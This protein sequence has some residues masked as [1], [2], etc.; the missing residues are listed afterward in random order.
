MQRCIALH[1]AT[2]LPVD[3]FTKRYLT[4]S[5]VI[6]SCSSLHLRTSPNHPCY[7]TPYRILSHHSL[8]STLSC[9]ALHFPVPIVIGVTSRDEYE[10]I[11]RDIRYEFYGQVLKFTGCAGV[12]FGHHSGDVEEN[13]IS[14]V[15]RSD[16]VPCVSVSCVL[17]WS[18][19]LVWCDPWAVALTA[20]A[21]WLTC[22]TALDST[23]HCHP[24][25]LF[26]HVSEF[27]LSPTDCAPYYVYEKKIGWGLAR[28]NN[29]GDEGETAT[30]FLHFPYLYLHLTSSLSRSLTVF[31]LFRLCLPWYSNIRPSIHLYVSLFT[32]RSL[33][34]LSSLTLSLS[35]TLSP[36]PLSLCHFHTFILQRDFAALSIRHDGGGCHKRGNCIHPLYS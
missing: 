34:V 30:L 19:D 26:D 5:I 23:W 18:S 33:T 10:R 24:M 6:A 36:F 17:V 8:F 7:R 35:H 13:V 21:V 15:M 31:L 1:Y 28:F 9:R 12:I 16:E 25:C 14:N 4:P 2:P 29:V 22:L 11:S 27:L 32:S 3:N 20:T